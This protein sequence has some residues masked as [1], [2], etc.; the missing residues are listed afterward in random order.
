VK[1]AKALLYNNRLGHD[2]ET[3]TAIKA[4]AERTGVELDLLGFHFGSVTDEPEK[5]LPRYDIVFASGLSA[6]EAMASGCAVIIVG[7]TSCGEMV[8]QENFD[9]FR[10]VNFSIATNSPLASA[11]RIASEILRYSAQDCAAVTARLRL[12]ADF[13]AAIDRLIGIYES[14]IESHRVIPTDARAELLANFRYLR[15]VV[16]LI[17]ATDDYL[18]RRWSSI[19][20][21]PSLQDAGTRLVRVERDL[22]ALKRS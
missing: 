9:R 13:R 21:T 3:V 4:A 8:L 6:I 7:R 12:V 11:D 10:Q 2:S 17:K 14:V 20:Q 16:P 22:Q 19:S 5:L 1:S 18:G 15:K